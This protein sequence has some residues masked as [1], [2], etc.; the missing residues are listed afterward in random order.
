MA[1]EAAAEELADAK[2]D[3][4]EALKEMDKKSTTQRRD[5]RRFTFTVARKTSTTVDEVGLRKALGAKVYDKFTERK[6]KNKKLEEAV[7]L[8]KVDG[9]TVAKYLTVTQG[10]PYVTFTD[11]EDDDGQ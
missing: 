7:E 3:V 2:G 5:G 4:I 11:K 10:D 1:V 8:G 6:L 9:L